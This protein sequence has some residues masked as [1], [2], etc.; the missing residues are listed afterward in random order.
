[1]APVWP[2]Y[3]AHPESPP[4]QAHIARLARDAR[5]GQGPWAATTSVFEGNDELLG[6]LP[7]IAV[8]TL[9]LYGE[10]DFIC[11]TAHARTVA[12]LAPGARLVVLPDCGHMPACEQPELFRDAVLGWM[13][14]AGA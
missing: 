3:F 1:Y 4:A 13:D 9:L 12:G 10:L 5:F 8:P 2:L 6:L 7:S 11:G 14:G